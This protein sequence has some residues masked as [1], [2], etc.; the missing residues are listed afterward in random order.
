MLTPAQE[1]KFF[2]D[3]TMSQMQDL[4]QR[5]FVSD[6]LYGHYCFLWLWGAPHSYE[7]RHQSFYRRM[8]ADAYW[9]RIDRVKAV[10]DRIRSLQARVPERIPFKLGRIN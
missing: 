1:I 5:G 10:I 3:H 6:K 9:R 2:L 4:K 8:G 7:Y